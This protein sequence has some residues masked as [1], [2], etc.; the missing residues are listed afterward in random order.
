MFSFESSEI[1]KIFFYRTSPVAWWIGCIDEF[2]ESVLK[3]KFTDRNDPNY[4]DD[5]LHIFA[6]N[7]LVRYHYDA[8]IQKLN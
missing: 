8:M 2:A 6:E 5:V 4:P 1:F 7:V 3:E